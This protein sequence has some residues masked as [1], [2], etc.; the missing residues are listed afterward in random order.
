MVPFYPRKKVTIALQNLASII[1]K[2]QFFSTFF[3]PFSFPNPLNSISLFS[4]ILDDSN[5]TPWWAICLL[6]FW[7]CDT[8]SQI[9]PRYPCIPDTALP[10]PNLS[11]KNFQHYLD[12]LSYF[13]IFF[14]SLFVCGFLAFVC[15][16]SCCGLILAIDVTKED[17]Q[18]CMKMI[19]EWS[20]IAEDCPYILLLQFS[21]IRKNLWT[22]TSKI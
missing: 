10:L 21:L 4:L 8:I 16:Y 20:R 15:R 19:A 22:F 13:S 6:W 2:F 3:L 14:S 17:K 11:Q 5:L 12:F 7:P 18:Q 9:P 1:P